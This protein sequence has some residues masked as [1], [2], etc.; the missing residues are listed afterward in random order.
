MKSLIV[1]ICITAAFAVS[2]I[3]VEARPAYAKKEKKNC[4]YCHAVDRGGG[5]R[6]FRGM[7]YGA[8]KLSFKGFDEKKEAAKAGV[9]ASATG[10]A[11]KPTKPYTGK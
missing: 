10:K 7:Y 8:H 5:P 1:A 3:Q 2:T 4:S 9:K 6:G 11:S